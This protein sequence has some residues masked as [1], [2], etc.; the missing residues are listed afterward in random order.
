MPSRYIFNKYLEHAFYVF[1]TT[2]NANE[3]QQTDPVK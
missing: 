3:E 2:D 1:C